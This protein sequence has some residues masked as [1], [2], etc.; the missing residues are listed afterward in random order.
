MEFSDF[1][2][3]SV[4]MAA[5]GVVVQMLKGFG[6]PDY[7]GG[8]ASLIFGTTLGG[9]LAI[10]GMYPDTLPALGALSGFFAG[11]SA[12]GLYSGGKA[13]IAKE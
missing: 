13:V 8:L 6:L 12:S 11:A 2:I 10:S 9:I 7:Y 4:V 3:F 1:A 5:S